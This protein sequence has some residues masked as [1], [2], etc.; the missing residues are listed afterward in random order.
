MKFPTNTRLKTSFTL[1]IKVYINQF[2]REAILIKFGSEMIKNK[3]AFIVD[4]EILKF[5][6]YISDSIKR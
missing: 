5:Q 6:L 1:H 4:I 3:F 2:A